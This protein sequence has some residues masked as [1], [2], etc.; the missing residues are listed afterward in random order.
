ML[1]WRGC[2]KL[3]RRSVIQHNRYWS[4]SHCLID[5]SHP[6]G[7]EVLRLFLI[8][9]IS[10]GLWCDCYFRHYVFREVAICCLIQS[11]IVYDNFVSTIHE[12]VLK[13]M[14]WQKCEA[15]NHSISKTSL[16]PWCNTGNNKIAH[17][18]T[19]WISSFTFSD[20]QDMCFICKWVSVIITLACHSLG[21]L[22]WCWWSGCIA[23][24]Y[25]MF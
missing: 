4:C 3:A 10:D 11:F 9:I 5:R 12:S 13:Q 17:S 6:V 16:L 7:L 14:D 21:H 20:F 25:F 15:L 8:T 19:I 1:W 24:Q 22:H 2:L 18:I 23:E